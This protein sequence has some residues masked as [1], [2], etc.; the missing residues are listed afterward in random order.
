MIWIFTWMALLLF[1][2]LESIA[3]PCSVNAQ[4]K[5]FECCPLFKVTNCDLKAFS[6]LPP[7]L[8]L[9]QFHAFG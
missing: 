4:G 6:S 2:M 1:K 5:Y 7:D 8:C 3:T 9:L